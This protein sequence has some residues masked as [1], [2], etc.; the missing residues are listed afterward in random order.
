MNFWT[1]L[2]KLKPANWPPTLRWLSRTVYYY[3]I[4][5]GLFILYV[6]LKQH[7]PPPFIYNGF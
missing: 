1:A 4:F 6:V 2:L 3:L 7:T 5:M